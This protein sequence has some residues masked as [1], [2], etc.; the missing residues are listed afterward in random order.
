MENFIRTLD[1]RTTN[2]NNIEE[3]TEVVEIIN[4]DPIKIEISVEA[5]EE[6]ISIIRISSITVM[7]DHNSNTKESRSREELWV[8]FTRTRMKS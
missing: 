5:A 6:V 8:S 4:S 7:G 1:P 3:V 2:T